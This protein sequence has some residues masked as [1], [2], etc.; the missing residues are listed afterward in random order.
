MTKNFLS[1]QSD[2]P[3]PSSHNH[4]LL[5]QAVLWLILVSIFYLSFSLPAH[6]HNLL[7]LS[8]SFR[9]LTTS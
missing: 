8:Q 3:Q 1:H 5:Y 2:H 4:K 9:K 7:I 6:L